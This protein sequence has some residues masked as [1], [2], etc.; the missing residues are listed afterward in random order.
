MKSIEREE[1]RCLVIS[2]SAHIS[3]KDPHIFSLPFSFSS[4]LF[5]NQLPSGEMRIDSGTLL[6]MLVE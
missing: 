5:Q 1:S 3:T 6:E 2:I 4:F